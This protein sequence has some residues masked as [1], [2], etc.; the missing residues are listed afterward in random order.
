MKT[1]CGLLL[2]LGGEKAKITPT[3]SE[4]FGFASKNQLIRLIHWVLDY[5]DC[6]VCFAVSV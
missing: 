3:D 6:T 1:T 5:T 4:R 2:K